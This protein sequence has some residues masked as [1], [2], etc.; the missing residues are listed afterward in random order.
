MD[1]LK[2]YFIGDG[3]TKKKQDKKREEKERNMKE[4]RMKQNKFE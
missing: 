1:L 3:S 4:E 2:R